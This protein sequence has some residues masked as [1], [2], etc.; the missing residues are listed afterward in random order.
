M[1]STILFKS[2]MLIV[3]KLNFNFAEIKRNTYL[4]E[5]LLSEYYLSL[6]RVVIHEV[7][8]LKENRSVWLLACL[9]VE[10]I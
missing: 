9:R 8:L 10:H 4:I 3:L 6:L 2:S 5:E 7:L 1:L